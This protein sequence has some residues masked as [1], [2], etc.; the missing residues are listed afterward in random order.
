MQRE[1]KH[2][3]ESP[4]RCP[5]P[6]ASFLLESLLEMKI[7][8]T[9]L[10]SRYDL[11][12]LGHLLRHVTFRAKRSRPLA[13]QNKSFGATKTQVQIPALPVIRCVPVTLGTNLLI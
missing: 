1:H 6:S 8:M 5:T 11:L 12:H 13:E 7:A 4:A 2:P 3:A 10:H 9:H